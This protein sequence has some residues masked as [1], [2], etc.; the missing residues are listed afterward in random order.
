MLYLLTR[1]DYSS[2]G[3]LCLVESEHEIYEAK[4]RDAID[5]YEKASELARRTKAEHPLEVEFLE[6]FLDV[7]H[8]DFTEIW[9]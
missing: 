1:G 9:A 2:Y 8:V 6:R 3:V 5:V 7:R 4:L